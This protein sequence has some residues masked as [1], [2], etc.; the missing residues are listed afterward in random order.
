MEVAL[1]YPYPATAHIVGLLGP[2]VP[3]PRAMGT[4]FA[5]KLA[6]AQ[7]GEGAV[8]QAITAA[9]PAGTQCFPGTPHSFLCPGGYNVIVF[10]VGV[11]EGGRRRVRADS[12]DIEPRE[13][14]PRLEEGGDLDPE[15][16][17]ESSDGGDLQDALSSGSE[18]SDDDELGDDLYDESIEGNRAYQQEAPT[19]C[20]QP[21]EH[22]M[23]R[24]IYTVLGASGIAAPFNVLEALRKIQKLTDGVR[25]ER[26]AGNRAATARMVA[27]GH[28]QSGK[29]VIIFLVSLVAAYHRIPHFVI[30]R[31]VNGRRDAVQ[32]L[33]RFLGHAVAHE[34]W[35]QQDI[36]DCLA[37]NSGLREGK[38]HSLMDGATMVGNDSGYAINNMCQMYHALLFHVR[39]T[40]PE[41]RRYEYFVTHDEADTRFRSPDRQ[42]QVEVATRNFMSNPNHYPLLSLEVSGTIAPLLIKMPDKENFGWD[43]VIF[44][45]PDLDYVGTG[46]ID[47]L[48][49]VAGNA[50][51]LEDGNLTQGNGYSSPAMQTMMD[52]AAVT[53]RA[54]HILMVTSYQ[55]GSKHNNFTLAQRAHRHYHRHGQPIAT[56]MFHGSGKLFFAPHAEAHTEVTQE[57]EAVANAQR[58]ARGLRAVRA[59]ECGDTI[60]YLD[61]AYPG[62][63]IFVFCY[64]PYMRSMSMRGDARVPTHITLYATRGIALVEVIQGMQRGCGNQSQA[65]RAQGFAKVTILTQKADFESVV[66]NAALLDVIQVRL[67]SGQNLAQAIVNLPDDANLCL[68]QQRRLV[69]RDARARARRAAAPRAGGARRARFADLDAA[70]QPAYMPPP[71]TARRTRRAQLRRERALGRPLYRPVPAHE[72]LAKLLRG[73]MGGNVLLIVDDALA[74]RLHTDARRDW[75]YVMDRVTE[76]NDGGGS[77]APSLLAL[78]HGAINHF[79]DRHAGPFAHPGRVPF[80]AEALV[81]GDENMVLSRARGADA[82][83]PCRDHIVWDTGAMAVRGD[84]YDHMLRL[85]FAGQSQPSSKRELDTMLRLAYDAALGPAGAGGG[86]G[87]A[88]AAAALPKR[89]SAAEV[90]SITMRA[91]CR[92]LRSLVRTVG[93]AA[94]AAL[95]RGGG[96]GGNGDSSGDT[97][98][99]SAEWL[100]ANLQLSPDHACLTD[101]FGPR[102]ECPRPFQVLPLYVP[103][104][105]RG[106]VLLMEAAG[107]HHVAGYRLSDFFLTRHDPLEAV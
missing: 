52:T 105:A 4:F 2:N 82:P 13:V 58:A 10:M 36:M 69:Q 70:A 44:T 72:V 35:A 25:A 88:T 62:V 11:A 37:R 38:L 101:A 103:V 24:T 104:S 64:K 8:V 73:V 18:P 45:E 95:G 39:N 86:G 59:A 55:F 47:V 91:F 51:Y 30:A 49:D 32:K 96:G 29:S 77:A 34:R 19:R 92:D 3:P 41:L 61:R 9:L 14:A 17:D 21:G 46:D 98:T 93:S 78:L 90:C 107:T 50:I 97:A 22:P 56:V 89:A 42:L 87:G 31:F 53:P 60:K 76:A 100:M 67:R 94:A 66:A 43:N 20:L 15:E 57:W 81:L 99:C 83:P 12:M 23:V 74:M 84:A 106:V 85:R 65:L 27:G 79:A 54:L 7:A 80:D 16:D 75:Q 68:N 28:C 63:P 33:N 48:R 102:A 26:A 6:E 5:Q 1:S 40:E 71:E